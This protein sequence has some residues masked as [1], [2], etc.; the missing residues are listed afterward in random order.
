MTNDEST[1][2]SET[3]EVAAPEVAAPQPRAADVATM[4]FDEQMAV[5]RDVMRRRSAVLR[6][7]AK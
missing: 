3:P 5:A 1:D 2:L 7:L 6:E 4:P